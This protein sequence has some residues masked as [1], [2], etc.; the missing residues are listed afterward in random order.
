[1]PGELDDLDDPT[2]PETPD[3]LLARAVERFTG[4]AAQLGRAI[5]LLALLEG[6]E[7][8]YFC[9][10]LCEDVAEF[11]TSAATELVAAIRFAHAARR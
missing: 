1:M 2:R 5:P 7:R 6:A 8:E 10:R 4:T 9:A 11:G 3:A